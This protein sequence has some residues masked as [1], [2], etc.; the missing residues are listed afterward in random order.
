[1]S[2]TATRYPYA[3]AIALAKRVQDIVEA[4]GAR[5]VIVGSLRR[6]RAEVGDIDIVLESHPDDVFA[7]HLI[8]QGLAHIGYMPTRMG[9][10]SIHIEAPDQPSIDLYLATKELFAVTMLVR[11]GSAAHN[12]RVARAAQKCL[13]AR[14]LAVSKG[15]LNSAGIVIPTSTEEEVFAALGMKYVEPRDREA[16]EFEHMVEREVDE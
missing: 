11:T 12:I 7:A 10:R 2:K 9:I 8:G 4:N 14:K 5:A 6:E 15:V 16:P 13:P 3:T 1:M